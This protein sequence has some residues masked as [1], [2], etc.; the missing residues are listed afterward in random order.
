MRSVLLLALAL[1][2][3]AELDLAKLPP[4]PRQATLA[5]GAVAEL[6]LAKLLLPDPAK[7]L[8]T[9]HRRS[10]QQGC[11]AENNYCDNCEPGSSTEWTFSS[12]DE[13]VVDVCGKDACVMYVK[14]SPA[15]SAGEA[16]VEL[17]TEF[18][19]AMCARDTCMEALLYDQDDETQAAYNVICD[20]SNHCGK[21]MLKGYFDAAVG[22]MSS[23]AFLTDHMSTLCG[24]AD[25][26]ET[27]SNGTGQLDA[28]CDIHNHCGKDMM[29]D[30]VDAIAESNGSTTSSAAQAAYFK[31]NAKHA[32][33]ICGN[34]DCK[35]AYS[36]NMT[37]DDKQELNAGCGIYDHC[38]EDMYTDMFDIAAES[39]GSVT[40]NETIRAF[41]IDNAIAVCGSAD[42]KQ[43]HH[44]AGLQSGAAEIMEEVCAAGQVLLIVATVVPVVGVC[45]IGVCIG[46]LLYAAAARPRANSPTPHPPPARP[47]A[48]A[49][50]PTA[51]RAAVRR[52]FCCCK[53]KKEPSV[54]ADGS[55]VEVK[56][57]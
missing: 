4:R 55:G 53:K 30:A 42:C 43:A 37:D 40:S 20:V 5:L 16:T 46:L 52:A 57:A 34:A 6:D 44:D 21:D 7:L 36:S 15:Y 29:T 11:T 39:N 51:A 14:Y 19:A 10:L 56:T 27:Y 25:C 31:Y 49:R 33:T 54:G 1:G 38:G 35:E 8:P 45:C 26:K 41:Y 24:N 9:L 28:F 13:S 32:S 12:T 17:T 2:V 48:R 50:R 22:N 3:A 18:Y 47:P 23:T